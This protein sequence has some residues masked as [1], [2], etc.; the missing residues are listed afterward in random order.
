MERKFVLQPQAI[1]RYLCRLGGLYP[2]NP[3]DALEVESAIDTISEIQYLLEISLDETLQGLMSGNAWTENEN[4]SVRRRIA[5]NKEC[6]L[7]FVSRLGQTPVSGML[8]FS[9]FS[10]N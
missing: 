1:L 8:S 7:P 9:F 4:W 2:S 3:I 6:G 10:P 5:K